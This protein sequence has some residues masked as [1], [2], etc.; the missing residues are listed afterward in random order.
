MIIIIYFL[1][2]NEYQ[3]VECVMNAIMR[4]FLR[5]KTEEIDKEEIVRVRVCECG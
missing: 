3:D 1:I 4:K 5:L 2:Q